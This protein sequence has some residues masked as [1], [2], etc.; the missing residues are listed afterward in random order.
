[1]TETKAS[2]SSLARNGAIMAAGSLVSRITGFGR[3]VVMG[4]AVGTAVGNAYTTAQY[5]P[6][7]IYELVLGGTLT[8]VLVPLIMRA[9]TRDTDG[10]EAFTHRLL[11]LSVMVLL[12]ATACVVAAAPLM[13]DLMAEGNRELVTQLSYLMLPAI[14]FYGLSALLQAVLNTRDHFAAPMWA[15]IL[16]NLVV[17]GVGASFYAIYTSAL[18]AGE[19]LTIDAVS[20]TMVLLLG[21]GT[22]AGLLVQSLALWPA[23][24]KVSFRWKWRFDFKQLHMGEIG[25]LAGWILVYVAVSQVAV[26]VVVKLANIAAHGDKYPGPIIYNNGYLVTMMAHGIVAVSVITAM[27]PRLSAAASER[28]FADMAAGLSS[29]TRLSTLILMPITVVY[30]VLGTPLAVVMFNW[31]QYNLDAAVS[32]GVVIA[33]GGLSLIPFAISQLQTFAFYAL[34]DG[35]TVALLNIPVVAV[36]IAGY[37]VALAVLDP[38]YGVAGLMVANGISYVVSV[39]LST[40]MLRKRVGLLGMRQIVSTWVRQ[41]IAGGVAF[42]AGWTVMEFLPGANAGLSVLIGELAGVGALVLLVYFLVAFVLRVPEIT[43]MTRLVRAK[44]GR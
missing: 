26:I 6:Q 4:A 34:T 33:V 30:V 22:T 3:N 31:G 38:Q 44:L 11:T 5:F 14:F 18:A 37:V 39:V 13:A 2:T 19:K 27:M 1:M 35:K 25:K 8:S 10:G 41:F 23:L 43:D 29:G 12:G 42:A 9:R 21:A 16:N 20:P 15:P 24:R 32:T 36:R 17:I 28:R 40:A 7:M